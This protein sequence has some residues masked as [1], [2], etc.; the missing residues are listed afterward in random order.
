MTL[1]APVI[2][3]RRATSRRKHVHAPAPAPFMRAVSVG[4]RHAGLPW[5]RR[6]FPLL[7]TLLILAL[8]PVIAYSQGLDSVV[9]VWT[10]PGDDGSVGTATSYEMRMSLS[11]ITSSNFAQAAVVPDL[12]PPLVSGSRQHV[13]VRGL[14]R[15]TIYYF[16]MRSTDDAGNRSALSNLLRWNWN[17]DESPPAAPSGLSNSHT[18]GQV[19]VAWAA[20]TEPDLTGYLV[21]RAESASGP[22]TLLT[23]T[24][25]TATDYTDTSVPAGASTVYYEVSALDGSGNQSARSSPMSVNLAAVTTTTTES[26]IEPGYPNP[27]RAAAAVH[28][29]VVLPSTGATSGIVDVLDSGDRRVR[30]IVLASLA[31]GRQE[32]LWDGKNDAGREVAPGVYRAWL[33]AGSTRS[34]IRLVR[35]P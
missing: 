27:S 25:I 21:Y 28:I 30:R 8:A 29:P 17:L 2:P 14:D 20:N 32:V 7:V 6:W 22:W 1:R 4:S 19:H 11:P 13:T 5:W 26:V 34:S 12:P 24:V 18:S 16:A 33:I 9:V 23:P 35:V 10:A 3:G 15:G 31:P